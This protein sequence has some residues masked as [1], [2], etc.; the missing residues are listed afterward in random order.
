MSVLVLRFGT[1][2]GGRV[3]YGFG[4]SGNGV[5]P[6]HLG[7]HILAGLAL[8]SDEPLTRLAVVRPVSRRMPP[9]PLR[10][11]GA[12]VQRAAMIAREDREE[13]GRAAPWWLRTFTSLPRR[14]GYRLGP[15]D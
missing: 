12:S 5:G 9:E 14:L 2:P 1:L 13:A 15:G 6:S 8:E 11:L 7:G 4:Y 10:W 3:H